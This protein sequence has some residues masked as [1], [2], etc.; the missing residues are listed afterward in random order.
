MRR[1]LAVPTA[2]LALAVTGPTAGAAIIELGFTKEAATPA[3]PDKPCLA[4]SRTTGYQAKV[5]TTRGL[6]TVPQSG[7]IVAWSINLGKPGP[8]QT[9]F[10]EKTLGGPAQAQISIIRPGKK[11]FGRV[12]AVSPLMTLKPYFGS[13]AQFPLVRSIPVR[14][15]Y[16]VALTVPT[17][18]PALAVGLGGDTSWRA[19]RA[20][21]KCDD[22]QTQTAQTAVSSLAQYYCL[23]RTAR[24]TYT[25]TLVTY[26]ARPKAA[27]TKPSTTTTTTPAKTTP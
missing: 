17:W 19:A 11:L 5:G 4:V 2:L 13:V 9:S 25:A 14:K 1:L 10:F 16:I 6:M 21:G 12:M 3:C 18:A 27:P 22:T 24:L 8:T 26:A 23:Y 20:K 15:D 7:R